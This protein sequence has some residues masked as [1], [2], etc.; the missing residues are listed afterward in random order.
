MV[1]PM[2]LKTVWGI[3]AACASG[4]LGGTLAS[5]GRENR[6][7]AFAPEVIRASRFELVNP[8]GITVANW[9][10][11]PTNEIRLRFTSGRGEALEIGALQDGRPFLRMRGRDG[12]ARVVMELDGLDKPMLGMG[13]E[14]WEGRVRLG[15]IEPDILDTGSD[16]WGLAFCPFG[17]TRPIV[18]MQM[19]KTAA[20]KVEGHLTVSGMRIR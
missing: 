7:E 8:A 4:F 13:D 11:T 12:K 17:T 6:V 19:I 10:V 5:Q 2:N 15:F 9:E 1:E 14:K 18:G 3:L 16:D 20:G